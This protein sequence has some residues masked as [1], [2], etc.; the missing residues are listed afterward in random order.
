M[1]V[2]PAALEARGDGHGAAARGGGWAAPHAAAVRGGAGAAE[3]AGFG[4]V[5]TALRGVCVWSC[6]LGVTQIKGAFGE[7]KS[8][9]KTQLLR[10]NIHCFCSIYEEGKK[11]VPERPYL[12]EVKLRAGITPDRPALCSERCSG[13]AAGTARGREKAPQVTPLRRGSERRPGKRWDSFTLS[14]GCELCGVCKRS[15]RE[16]HRDEVTKRCF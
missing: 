3:G 14:H 9:D 11:S 1:D 5:G 15:S 8:T 13:G 4:R 12:F 2:V 6:A 10:L 16:K 7:E